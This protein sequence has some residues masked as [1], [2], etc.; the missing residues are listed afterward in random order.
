MGFFTAITIP[1]ETAAA[2]ERLHADL[3]GG[4]WIDPESYHITLNYI[5]ELDGSAAGR[6]IEAL[7]G[8]RFAPFEISLRGL[9]IFGGGR[10]RAV[11]AGAE[12]CPELMAM[13]ARQARLIAG[14]GFKL[15]SRKYTPHVT[16][17]RFR[18][19]RR[20]DLK[21]FV[22][23]RNVYHAPP[24]TCDGYVLLSSRPNGGGGPYGTEAVFS[25]QA[26][27][28]PDMGEETF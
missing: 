6:L 5:G 11:W 16:L 15:E 19:G 27:F 23:R 28:L 9:G 12:P 21:R 26:G 4:R 14:A 3:H 7:D 24:F 17:A 1:A 8:L 13:Q 20:N 2:L 25:G 10:P 18:E 22:E